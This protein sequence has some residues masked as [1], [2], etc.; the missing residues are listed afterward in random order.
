MKEFWNYRK[1]KCPECEGLGIVEIVVD[2][3][4]RGYEKCPIGLCINGKVPLYVKMELEGKEKDNGG[5]QC[6]TCNFFIDTPAKNN[7]I[8]CKL[9]GR[10]FASKCELWEAKPK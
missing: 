8:L 3:N 10:I 7:K 6:L 1:V 5:E 2:S 9:K 4:I